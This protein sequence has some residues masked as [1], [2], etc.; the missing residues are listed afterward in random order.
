M[1]LTEE[2]HAQRRNWI[3]ASESP[4]LLGVSPHGNACSVWVQKVLDVPDVTTPAEEVGLA[5]EEA[6][7]RLY[8]KRTN[9]EICPF[10]SVVHPKYPFMGCTPD[11]AVFGER[12]LAQVKV[13]GL[14]MADGWDEDMVPEHV[15]IQIQHELEVCN[16]DVGDAVA[17]IGT[18]LRI[19]PV[20]RDREIGQGL[21]EICHDFWKRYVVT[22]EMPPVDASTHATNMLKARFRRDDGEMLPASKEFDALAREWLV[23]DANLGEF[24]RQRDEIANHM[25]AII[26]NASGVEGEFYRATWKANKNGARSFLCK[27]IGKRRKAA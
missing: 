9:R 14:W 10:G 11:F 2:Q 7:A 3:G 12:R 21:V 15:Q 23:A 22:R 8:A 18:D 20:E 25:K 24:D 6:I 1:P 19:L 26:G 13:V 16:A 27:E 4:C 5:L 17:L